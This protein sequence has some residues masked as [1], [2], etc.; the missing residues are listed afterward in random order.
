MSL[1]KK[2]SHI[3]FKKA[4]IDDV[5]EFLRIEKTTMGLKTYSGT[6][7]EPG[8]VEEIQN[9]GNVYFIQKNGINVGTIQ[10]EIKDLDYAYLSRIVIDP[11]FQGQGI[12][13]EALEWLFS[14]DLKNFKKIDL[15]THPQNTRAI[16]LYLSLGFIIESWKDNCFGDGEP[17]IVLAREI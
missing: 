4:T 2:K 11:K 8:A 1:F 16:M 6:F 12:A 10:Y 5:E 3:T 9:N 7:D 13:R 15:E 17:R 14:N